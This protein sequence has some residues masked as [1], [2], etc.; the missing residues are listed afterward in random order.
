MAEL[1]LERLVNEA[2]RAAI[3]QLKS[4]GALPIVHCKDCQFSYCHGPESCLCSVSNN[5]V[6]Y[7]DDYCSRGRKKVV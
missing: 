3:E 2:A 5:T 4:E 6:V 1:N 7:L